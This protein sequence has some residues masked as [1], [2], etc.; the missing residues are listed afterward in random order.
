MSKAS[1]QPK[2]VLEAK[3]IICRRAVYELFPGAVVNVGVGVAPASG[4]GGGGRM[5]GRC[6]TLG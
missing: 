2:A 3:D 6:F 4:G 1:L 5:D